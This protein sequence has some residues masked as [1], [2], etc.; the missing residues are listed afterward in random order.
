MVELLDE[1]CKVACDNCSIYKNIEFLEKENT[2]DSRDILYKINT[3]EQKL[4]DVLNDTYILNKLSPIIERNDQRSG[5]TAPAPAPAP[6]PSPSPSPSPEPEPA[7][8]DD[9][10]TPDP[11]PPGYN[12]TNVTGSPSKSSF[13]IT[14]VE[15]ATGYTGTATAAACSVAGQ[16]YTLSGCSPGCQGCGDTYPWFEVDISEEDQDPI[17]IYI[18]K[19]N[20]VVDN[21][22]EDLKNK[23]TGV[24][25]AMTQNMPRNIKEKLRSPENGWASN[26][27]EEQRVDPL[28]GARVVFYHCN[29]NR[30][31][32]KRDPDP[33]EPGYELLTDISLF[34][35]NRGVGRWE[36]MRAVYDSGDGAALA[37]DEK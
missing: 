24:I 19:T 14:G 25:E 33:V 7:S 8:E 6:S 29:P 28:P 37:C 17:I 11:V 9:C 10:T 35:E 32:W 31:V 2:I 12:L 16:D 34:R 20:L 36:N 23:V 4:K 26:R 3:L 27:Y 1:A 22:N 30:E 15:C 5:D 18:E 13:T 21:Q